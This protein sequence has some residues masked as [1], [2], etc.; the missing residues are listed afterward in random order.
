[1]KFFAYSF[2][3]I[4]VTIIACNAPNF[5]RMQRMPASL[6]ESS[7]ILTYNGSTV[8]THNDSGGDPTLYEIDVQSGGLLRIVTLAG[9]KNIDWEDITKDERGN[10]FIGDFGNN[11]QNRKNLCIYKIENPQ[12]LA[13][14]ATVLSERIGFSYADQQKFP[15]S[16][17]TQNFDCEAFVYYRDSLYLFTKNHSRPY[18]GYT[19]MYRLPAVEGDYV[20]ELVDSFKTGATAA[21]TFI[22][23]A[24]ISPN[25]KQLALLS[26]DKVFL[27]SNWKG[28]NFFQGDLR[29][30][31][32]GTLSQKEAICFSTNWTLWIGDERT[33]KM[34]GGN[35]YSFDLR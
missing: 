17:K 12:P 2:I 30:I 3:L 22:T 16:A 31:P 18:T 14:S 34:I 33:G 15:P 28:A 11:H 23:S 13:A 8:W 35:I 29:R 5:T 25:G 20:A 32:L 26:S 24:A 7:G 4:L 9:V 27:F 21:T 6:R 1:M 19:K 10:V